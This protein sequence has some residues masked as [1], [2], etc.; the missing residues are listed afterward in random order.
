MATNKYIFQVNTYMN[1]FEINPENLKNRD[2]RSRIK[3]SV[4]GIGQ[5][6]FR[7]CLMFAK[8]GYEVLA[9]DIDEEKIKKINSGIPPIVSKGIQER[10]DNTRVKGSINITE[11]VKQSDVVIVCVPTPT[12]DKK[13][14]LSFIESATKDVS[15]GLKSGMIIIYE[16]T[17]YPSV[18]EEKIIPLLE[19]SGLKVN[20][21]FGVVYCPERVDPG[22]K[23][24]SVENIPR[25]IAASDKKILEVSM[26][27]Y[28]T[29]LNAK[30]FPTSDIKTAEMGKLIENTFRDIN[31]AFINE[32]A[33]IL[34]GTEIDIMEAIKAASTKPF[35][36]IPHYPGCGVGGDCIPVSP[37]WLIEFAKTIKKE[38]K[39]VELAR[40]INESM[41][42]F[43]VE[44]LK[45]KLLD[46]GKDIKNAKIL[47]L[48]LTY[49]EDVCDTR[50]APSKDLTKLL[51]KECKELYAYDPYISEERVEKEFMITKKNLDELNSIDAIILLTVHEEF[52]KLDF[53]KLKKRFGK[54]CIFFDTK[55]FFNKNS[56]PFNY[57]GMGR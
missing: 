55:N 8:T 53:E 35:A 40:N 56:I 20:E 57:I 38:P 13:P 47:I 26:A 41:P 11:G 29:V 48:G 50:N 43:V 30:L 1:F 33:K 21:D 6:G 23:K 37:Y 39:L 54:N 34:D 52:K 51:K 36:F 45:K 7:V 10:F 16:S 46:V 2:F 17:V 25:V 49:K 12:K 44:K 4:I 9:L 18:I 3:I 28:K 27:L 24:F 15:K 14:D 42:N 22:N 19:T 32:I 5:I 31:I